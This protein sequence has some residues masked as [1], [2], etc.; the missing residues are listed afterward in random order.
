MSAGR[1]ALI[2]E[3]NAKFEKV[4]TW[5]KADGTAY[6][7]TGY[8]AK[9]QVRETFGGG[10]VAD[11]PT[12]IGTISLGGAAGTITVAIPTAD[13]ATLEPGRYVYD[14]VLIDGSAERYRVLEGEC[15]ITPGVTT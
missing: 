11:I 14:L 15:E 5:K 2:I 10:L 13:T 3:Q 12:D 4:F 9:M 8:T 7:L 1:Y 6:N